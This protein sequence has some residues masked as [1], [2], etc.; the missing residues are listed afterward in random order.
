M[1]VNRYIHFFIKLNLVFS[2]RV[3]MSFP[4][5]TVRRRRV[6]GRWRN[7]INATIKQP[8]PVHSQNVLAVAKGLFYISVRHN[9]TSG[10]DWDPYA[11]LSTRTRFLSCGLI[12]IDHH[13]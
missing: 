4:A 1:V 13:S 9:E 6:R 2:P 3:M 7:Y 12:T 5:L 10:V 8:T 11:N